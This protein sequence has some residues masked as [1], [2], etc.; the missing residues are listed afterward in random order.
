MKIK[1]LQIAIANA[2]NGVERLVQGG[3]RAFAED[4]RTVYDE[5]NQFIAGGGVALVVVT[6]DV[7]RSAENGEDGGILIDGKLLVR[8]VERCP[9]AGAAGNMRA[10]DAAEAVAHELDRECIKFNCIRQTADRAGRTF[11]ATA[12]FDFSA[13]LTKE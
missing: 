7:S 9:L 11:T 2:L 5:S 12:E 8:C 10:L 13:T 6:P 1:D 4:T 3:C